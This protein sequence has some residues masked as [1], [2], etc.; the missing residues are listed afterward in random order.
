MDLLEWGLFGLFISSFLA[1]TV[2]PFGSEG[3]LVVMLVGGYDPIICV[4]IATLGNW[5]GGMSSYFLGYIG[6]W[7]WINKYLKVSQEKVDKLKVHADRFGAF[8]AAAC[9]LP[10]VGDVLAI[11]LGF[12]R[13]HAGRVGIWMFLGKFGR[14]VVVAYLTLVVS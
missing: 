5:L 11:A 7:Q 12:F 8:S 6:K 14:Y 13:V 9:W 2:I 4:T 3:I 1:A 10:I